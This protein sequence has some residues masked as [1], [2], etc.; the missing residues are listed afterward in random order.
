MEGLDRREPARRGRVHYA[1]RV[2][3]EAQTPAQAERDWWLRLALVL[4]SPSSVFAWLRD[5]SAEATAARQEPITAVLFLSGIS[6]FLST[7]TAGRLFDE[8][9]FDALLVVVEAV[10]AGLLVAIQNFW[11]VGGAVYLGGRA[12]DS[13]ASYR[14]VRHVVALAATPFV[15]SLVF[16]WPVRLAMFGSDSFRSGGSDHGTAEAVFRAFDATFLVWSLGLLVVG[17]RTLNGWRWPRSL[18]SLSIAAVVLAAV[19]FLFV[20]IPVG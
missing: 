13:S 19:I 20:G 2:S 15:L 10:I 1:G 3:A 11:I 8:I 17:V 16:V 18:A 12:A 4:Q 7:R 14:Q 9:E 5:D 6:I